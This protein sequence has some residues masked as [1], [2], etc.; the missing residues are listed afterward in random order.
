MLTLEWRLWRTEVVPQAA[1][2][3]ALSAQMRRPP[4][5]TATSGLRRFATFTCS[6]RV[7]GLGRLDPLAEA[8]GDDRFFRN[9]DIA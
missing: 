8:S 9:C 3:G 4:P 5:R 7:S 2:E 1:R 6:Q